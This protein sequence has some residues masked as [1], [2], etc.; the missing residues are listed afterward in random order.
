MASISKQSNGGKIVQFIDAEGKRQSIRLG[1][2]PMDWAREVKRH[3][4]ALLGA[5]VQQTTP[6]RPT[7]EWIGRLDPKLRKR[8]CAVGL[9]EQP[10]EEREAEEEERARQAE[11]AKAR[12][13]DFLTAYMARRIDVKPATKEVW[14]QT[15]RNLLEFFGADRTL[16]S[17]TE[18]DA[19]DFKLYLIG[20]NLASTT[21]HKRLQ[22]ARQ[23]FRNAVKR[24]L[25]PANPFLEVTAK[26]VT[27]L[28]GERFVSSEETTQIL[29]ACPSIHWKVIV[30]LCRWG[31]LRCPSE[32]LSLRWTAI[33]WERERILVESPKTAH[34]PG[35]GSREI[36]LFPELKPILTEASKQAPKG[37]EFVVDERYRTRAQGRNGW[38]NC[39]LRT[40]FERIIRRAGLETWPKLFHALRKSR[41]TELVQTHPLHVVTNWLGNTPRIAM[42]HYLLV[43]DADF[44]KALQNPVH[45]TAKALQKAVRP[46]VTSSCTEAQETT[47]ALGIQGLVLVGAIPGNF[48]QES[49]AERTG[50]PYLSRR[51]FL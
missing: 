24:K 36:P 25:A 42:K 14:S 51:A 1:K 47:Q 29:K 35:K 12:L 3:V 40:Q 44:Q 8:L 20:E 9:I 48:V 23:F 50:L 21:V 38:R 32:V 26:A 28:E 49:R 45:S 16:E 39:N 2:A 5:K 7:L 43:T 46:G 19:E 33:D 15:Q 18:G 22:F 31:G 34:H 10:V 41:E 37:A 6:E 13:G 27:S 30:A 4:E 17:I 11:E